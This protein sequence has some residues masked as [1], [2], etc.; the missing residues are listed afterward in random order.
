MSLSQIN[1]FIE[2]YLNPEKYKKT[3]HLILKH[4]PKQAKLLCKIACFGFQFRRIWSV[5]W[6]KLKYVVTLRV[7]GNLVFS[8]RNL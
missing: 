6:A 2:H 5:N 4:K 7:I 1:R 3:N 8:Y